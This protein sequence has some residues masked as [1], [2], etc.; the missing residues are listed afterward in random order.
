[1]KNIG[2]VLGSCFGQLTSDILGM[3]NGD[4]HS[5]DRDMVKIGLVSNES[6]TCLSEKSVI[7]RGIFLIRTE[8]RTT[9]LRGR[10]GTTGG[11]NKKC[12][13]FRLNL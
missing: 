9:I 2:Q 13:V 3:M 8:G 11:L 5:T 1:M 10:K 12:V 4:V 6:S 7:K